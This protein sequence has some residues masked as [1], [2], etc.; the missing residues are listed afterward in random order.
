LA[1][2]IALLRPHSGAFG[3]LGPSS[4]A[5]KEARPPYTNGQWAQT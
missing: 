3:R 5:G 4:F 2:R 1:D